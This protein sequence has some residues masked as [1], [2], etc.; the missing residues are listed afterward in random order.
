MRTDRVPPYPHLQTALTDLQDAISSN[1]GLISYLYNQ[2]GQDCSSVTCTTP[3]WTGTIPT[4]SPVGMVV[5]AMNNYVSTQL[6]VR[7]FGWMWKSCSVGS[8][9]VEAHFNDM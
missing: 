6:Q 8:G 3:Y 2:A 7:G 4:S 9:L 1:S 5:M